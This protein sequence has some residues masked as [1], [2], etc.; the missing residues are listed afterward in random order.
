MSAADSYVVLD[1]ETGGT[2][3][4]RHP[5]IQVAMIA[6]TR[7]WEPLEELDVRIRFSEELAEPEALKLNSY[8]PEV[9]AAKALH[10]R[11]AAQQIGDFLRRHAGLELVSQKGNPYRVAQLVAHRADFDA[12]FLFAFFRDPGWQVGEAPEEGTDP[13]VFCPAF[14]R[15][16]CT[17][18]LMQWALL[19]AGARPPENMKLGTLAK[20][21]GIDPGEAHDALSDVRVALEIARRVTR[22]LRYVREEP[23]A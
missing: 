5:L 11:D 4:R 6:C 9:W 14:F 22:R 13:R 16:L 20:W 18:Q 21:L 15:P 7:A 12:D 23:K 17:L 19:V 2:D 1:T 10:P 8:D 3:P